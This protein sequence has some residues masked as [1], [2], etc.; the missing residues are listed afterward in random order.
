MKYIK[1][2]SYRE[3]ELKKTKVFNITWDRPFFTKATQNWKFSLCFAKVVG[4]SLPSGGGLSEYIQFY[5]KFQ[6]IGNSK[7][8]LRLEFHIKIHVLAGARC[9]SSTQRTGK[10]HFFSETLAGVSS[11]TQW[12]P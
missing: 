10:G 8:N 7:V 9:A 4:R 11:L 6:Y 2:R 12:T 1:K 3:T 5:R